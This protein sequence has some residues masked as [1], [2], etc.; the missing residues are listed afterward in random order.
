MSK[1]FVLGAGAM[2]E[3]FIKGVLQKHVVSPSDITVINRNRPE[4]LNELRRDYGIRPA[5]S[6]ADAEDSEVII[7][8]VKPYDVRDA[9]KE[10]SPF[11]HG[12]TLISFAAGI[13]IAFMDRVVEG[14]A[15]VI[16]TMPNV[17]VAVLEGAIA[18]AVSERV[19][20][21]Q[22]ERAKQLL[23]QIGTVV[24]LDEELMDA[25]TAFSGSG[26][27]FVSYFLEAM[28]Q[29]A[30]ELGFSATMARQLLIQTVVGTAKVLEEWRLSP[31]DL[32]ERVTSPNGT[33]HAGLAV[34]NESGMREAILEALT[35]A[36][37]R[38]REMGEEYTSE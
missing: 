4:R 6:I 27:G 10:L 35:Q 21:D 17:P 30:V 2:A 32:R 38:S 23:R 20:A 19:G 3:S 8:S 14:R 7:V 1:I 16:R 36:A 37:K 13:P 24:E 5:E 25:A 18:M 22:L 31:T 33:T 34:L 29:A 28:E 11:L 12:Q 15:Q 9:L 26:P